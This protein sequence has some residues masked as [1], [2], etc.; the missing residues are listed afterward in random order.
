MKNSDIT[1]SF[2]LFGVFGF[3]EFVTERMPQFSNSCF[4]K[5]KC[6]YRNHDGS[7]NSASMFP[8]M[9]LSNEINRY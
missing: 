7:E 2:G 9:R 5:K 3:C 6:F 4:S 1:Q 8:E